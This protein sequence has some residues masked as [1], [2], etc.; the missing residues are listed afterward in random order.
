MLIQPSQTAWRNVA[1][2]AFVPLRVE[3]MLDRHTCSQLTTF[4]MLGFSCCWDRN[5]KFSY[6]GKSSETPT[7]L[8]FGF[9]CE[10]Q[11]VNAV[12]VFTR[13]H[14]FL[15]CPS[16]FGTSI[17]ALCWLRDRGW[18]LQRENQHLWRMIGPWRSKGS[19]TSAWL[20]YFKIP[21]S[22]GG[23]S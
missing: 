5:R 7:R 22:L 15:R 14:W 21:Q 20:Q 23:T 18:T 4:A 2:H 3:F 12:D 6:M 9:F 10:T 16:I 8:V 19:R 13:V 11:A 17:F 1:T